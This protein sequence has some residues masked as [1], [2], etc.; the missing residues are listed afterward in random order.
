MN[1]RIQHAKTRVIA[2]G[3]IRHI[4]KHHP[5]LYAG[6]LFLIQM[7]NGPHLTVTALSL[8]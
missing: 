3:S 8:E 1:D 6:F 7:W 2:D 5:V 4:V